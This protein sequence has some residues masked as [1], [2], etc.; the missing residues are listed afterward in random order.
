MINKFKPLLKY[1]SVIS[2][3]AGMDQASKTYVI[4]FLKAQY[5]MTYK[6]ASFFSLVFA[7]NHGISFGLFGSYLQYSNYVFLAINCL[8]VGYLVH[9]LIY[10]K[11]KYHSLGIAVI[12]G[13]ASGNIIDRIF[14]GA[15]FDFLY[16]HYG[17]YSFPAFNL[18]DAFINIGVFLIL[19]SYL[20]S[21]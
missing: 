6:V 16:F 13:G 18:A 8:I 2:V 3:L 21:K 1:L 7:W 11:A 15:V 5:G 19:L 17:Y 10:S 9:M 14:R 12:I 20:K 4:G